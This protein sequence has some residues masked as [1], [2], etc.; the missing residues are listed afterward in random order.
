MIA[1]LLSAALC[2]ALLALAACSKPHV[3]QTLSIP[4]ESTASAP[5]AQA[6]APAAA[7][8]PLP[9]APSIPAKAYIL[10]DFASGQTLAA[11]R[12]DDRMEP[13]SI[14]K[15]MSAYAV[16]KALQ[17]KRI[18]LTDM[19]T[20]SAH[21]RA[22]DG[23]RMFVEVGTQVNVENLIQGMIVQSGN[24]ATVALAERVAGSEPVFVDLMNKYA[25]QL[26]LS[27]SHFQDS[28]GMPDP[29]HYM[30]PRDIATLS[31]ALIREFPQYYKWYSQR[32]FTWNNITQPN[33]NGLLERDPTV[34]GLK[35]GHTDSA[36]Y[37]LVSSAKRENMRL[38][39]VVLG[40]ASTSVRESSSAALLNYGFS[41]Y[42]V[43]RLYA[44][45]QVVAK[46]H[47][48]KGKETEVN[49]ALKDDI[50]IVLPRGQAAATTAT[51]EL[52]DR[53]FAPVSRDTSLGTLKVLRGKDAIGTY[54][55]YPLN[56]VAESGI[57]GRALDTI[58]LWFK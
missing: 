1:R 18:A 45:N 19:V 34:D 15:L 51:V 13:A 49:L 58:K 6:G 42:E 56:D 10:V 57:F 40:T 26:G 3:A 8:A 54:P 17:D 27:N 35:T 30:S 14:T 41:F 36:G 20:I 25:L 37:C 9:S 55:V 2:I 43:R 48:W 21:A 31:R 11:N 39:S 4:V 38:I 12:P 32:Q 44:A 33:R 7:P 52:Q 28:T 5:P 29:Q 53:I 23:S 46:T 24:D 22:Q 16:F 47:V 50:N